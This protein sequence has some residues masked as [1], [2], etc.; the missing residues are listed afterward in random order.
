MR[1]LIDEGI[2]MFLAAK[3][4]VTAAS[5]V[6]LVMHSRFRLFNALR[7]HHV[8]YGCASIYVTLLAYELLLWRIV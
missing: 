4:L 7:V 1:L 2:V 6:F 5:V 8:L 3:Y